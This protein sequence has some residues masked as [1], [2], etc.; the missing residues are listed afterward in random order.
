MKQ[1]SKYLFFVFFALAAVGLWSCG[2]ADMKSEEN[3]ADN[4]VDS[5]SSDFYFITDSVEGKDQT[6]KDPGPDRNFILSSASQ[7]LNDLS[8]YI[9]MIGNKNY[10]ESFRKEAEHISIEMFHANDKLLSTDLQPVLNFVISGWSMD[11]INCD[12]R[13]FSV[14]LDSVPDKNGSYHGTI[15]YKQLVD[16]FEM[17]NVIIHKEEDQK[18]ELVVKKVDKKFGDSSEMTWVLYFGKSE[19]PFA[20]PK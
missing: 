12:F 15:R 17:K 16:I 18:K 13:N 3:A 20:S 19:H 2:A 10:D 8:G 6:N 1:V 14:L 4:K 9:S 5:S 11:S 7:K